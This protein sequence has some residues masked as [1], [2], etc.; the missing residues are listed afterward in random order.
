MM[1]CLPTAWVL[2]TATHHRPLGAVAF[3]GAAVLMTIVALGVV[4]PLLKPASK[5]PRNARLALGMIPLLGAIVALAIGGPRPSSAL[6][7]I[8]AGV[9]VLVLGLRVRRR[10]ALRLPPLV[11]RWVLGLLITTGMVLFAV[12]SLTTGARAAAPLVLG[13]L[14][15][16]H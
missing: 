15:L 10:G 9:V 11:S 16:S 2:V 4:R 8:G 7:E 14:A 6:I 12:P 13:L 1:L 5:I 3:G